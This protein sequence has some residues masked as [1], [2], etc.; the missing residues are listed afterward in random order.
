MEP[1]HVPK[2]TIQTDDQ[3][4]DF[5][6]EEAFSRLQASASHLGVELNPVAG[7]LYLADE[8]LIQ[9]FKEVCRKVVVSLREGRN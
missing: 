2:P 3:R 4:V 6:T 1:I 5:A 9:E 8:A 7:L